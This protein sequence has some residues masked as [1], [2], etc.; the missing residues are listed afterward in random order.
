MGLLKPAEGSGKL[1]AFCDSDWEGCL[2]WGKSV[3]GYLV[4]FGSALV[5]WK[6]KK[7]DTVARS[8]A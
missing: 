7:Q 5:S 3:T 6:S 2:Q 8:S 4:K 1:E